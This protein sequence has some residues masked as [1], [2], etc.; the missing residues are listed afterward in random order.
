VQIRLTRCRYGAVDGPVPDSSKLTPPPSVAGV[1]PWLSKGTAGAGFGF[2][3]AGGDV[4]VVGAGARVCV[5]GDVR[6]DSA[7]GDLWMR[8]ATCCGDAT[9][10]AAAGA[11]AAFGGVACLTAA[12]ARRAT[13][14]ALTDCRVTAGAGRVRGEY[15]AAVRSRS[16]RVL[17]VSLTWGSVA[18]LGWRRTSLPT[19]VVTVRSPSA[20]APTTVTSAQNPGRRRIIARTASAGCGQAEDTRPAARARRGY[21]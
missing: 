8:G 2:G 15:V 1:E 20:T 7:A 17:D 14:G 11:D 10:T 21:G 3:V 4:R 13:G 18:G 6:G 19:T 9:G 5:C 12:C 16:G